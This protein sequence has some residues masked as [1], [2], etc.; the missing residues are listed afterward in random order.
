[1]PASTPS[2][3][4]PECEHE[5]RRF[6]LEARGLSFSYGK[7]PVLDSAA[8]AIMPGDVAFLTGCNGSGKSTLLRCLAGWAHPEHGAILLH[9]EP[10]NPANRMQRS[11]IAFVPDVPSF[12]DDLT[13]REH[14]EFYGAAAH[15]PES[16]QYA[17]EL[18]ERFGMS[19]SLDFSPLSYSRGMKQKLALVLAIAL[20][21]SVLLL[22]EPFAP[23]DPDART[24]LGNM[25]EEAAQEGTA[26]ILSCHHDIYS[27]TPSRIFALEDG[28]IHARNGAQP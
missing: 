16:P 4:N 6:A 28:T 17:L 9:G 2:T 18:V 11:Q 27:P 12:Y 10:F 14:I 20:K 26:I 8:L 3:T 15:M 21:P 1:M 22:D 13:A 25:L 7:R 19:P 23:L 24:V 5:S